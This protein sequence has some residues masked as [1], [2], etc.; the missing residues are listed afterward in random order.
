[1]N[2]AAGSRSKLRN[3]GDLSNSL[4]L[5]V[6]QFNATT[7]FK[8]LSS[9]T[10]KDGIALWMRYHLLDYDILFCKRYNQF[11][12]TQ[13]L[14]GCTVQYAISE[15]SCMFYCTSLRACDFLRLAIWRLLYWYYRIYCILVEW[16][17]FH[18][19][20]S[21]SARQSL[22]WRENRLNI[23]ADRM[24]EIMMLFRVADSS[25]TKLFST[26]SQHASPITVPVPNP[27]LPQAPTPIR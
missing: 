26:V 24:Q 3:R 14:S 25:M 22:R 15:S 10:G 20:R 12:H 23:M 7:G 6:R 13:G 4:P 16:R 11:L 18:S 21:R 8:F 9:A 2:C 5:P 19:P 27:I 1:M 17:R